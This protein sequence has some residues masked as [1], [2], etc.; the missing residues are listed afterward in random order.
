MRR[1]N[2][3]RVA[4]IEDRT[5]EEQQSMMV[6]LESTMSWRI[7]YHKETK[8]MYMLR[9]DGGVTVMVDADGKPLLYEE[10]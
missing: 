10:D 7:V 6:S 2:C 4:N 9:T 1:V 5:T 3:I 8:V